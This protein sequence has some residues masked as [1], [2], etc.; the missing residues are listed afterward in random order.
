MSESPRFNKLAIFGL[1]FVG[2]V[3]GGLF[4]SNLNLFSDARTERSFVPTLGADARSLQEFSEVFAGIAE[5]VKPSVVLIQSKK[6]VRVSRQDTR[7]NPLFDEFFGPVVPMPQD[8]RPEQGLGSGVIVSKDGYILTN[9]HV[10]DG[11]DDITV[12][13]PDK[14]K[15][16]AELI[17]TDPRT[18]IAVIKVKSDALPVLPFGNSDKLRVGEWVMAVGNPFGLE[19]TVTAGIVSAKGRGDVLETGGRYYYQDFIQ[20]D[21][22]INPGNSG[23]ALV[24]LDGNLMG[25]NTAIFSRTGGYQG[26]GFAI[27]ANMARD[28]MTRLIK[29]GKITRGYLGV[30]IQSL[31]EEIATS[32]GLPNNKGAVVTEISKDGPAAKS[33]LKTGDVVTSL[34]GKPVQD[35][36]DL[37]NR[38]ASIA[39]GT[40]IALDVLRNGKTVKVAVE[41]GQLPDDPNQVAASEEKSPSPASRLGIDVQDITPDMAR[42]FN[43][44]NGVI[45]ARVEPGSVSEDKGLRRGD[46]IREVNGENVSDVRGFVNIVRKFEAGRAIRFLIQRGQSQFLVGIRIPE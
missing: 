24:D 32:M 22:A 36:D 18:D 3:L 11:A 2:M 12:S 23:G 37:R 28:I 44:E 21:A 10:I 40:E 15:F 7:R 27:P 34:N 4:V 19:H 46:V 38:I 25:I 41:L 5:K 31:D 35:S 6:S 43:L 45:I 30:L 26:I 20:T 39:P 9:N 13:L 29:D 1:L 14:R 42:Q 17:G 33:N 8:P 16:K